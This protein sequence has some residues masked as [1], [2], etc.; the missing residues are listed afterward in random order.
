MGIGISAIISQYTKKIKTEKGN[1]RPA[2]QEKLRAGWV[3]G[4]R[5]R[6]DGTRA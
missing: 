2:M 5:N 1:T 6:H 3:F 4:L